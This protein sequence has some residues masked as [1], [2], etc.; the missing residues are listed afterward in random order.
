ME[1]EEEDDISDESPL[2]YNIHSPISTLIV[3]RV[4]GGNAAKTREEEEE[5]HD[6]HGGPPLT[7]V[8]PAEN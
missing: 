8:L 5:E 2:I 7:L 6:F 1:E 3:N 4:R